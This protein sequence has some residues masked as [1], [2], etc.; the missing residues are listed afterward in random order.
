MVTE[1]ARRVLLGVLV[2]ALAC[3]LQIPLPA[4]AEPTCPTVG[5]GGSVTPSP[6][7][8]G[9]D[10]TDCD[11]TGALLV[12]VVLSDTN[13][14][15]ANLTNVDF[16][17]ATLTNANFTNATL[18]DATLTGATIT[19]ATFTPGSVLNTRVG[20]F[21][22]SYQYNAG[23]DTFEPG[24]RMVAYTGTSASVTIPGSA[25]NLDVTKIDGGAFADPSA[26]TSVTFANT[27]TTI[28]YGAF[29]ET[30]LTSLALPTSLEIIEA[31][32]FYGIATLGGSLS[33]PNS[34]TSI[35]DNAFKGTGFTSLTLG[36]SL[37]TIG[38]AA[39]ESV[40]ISGSL[41]IPSSTT[42]IGASAFYGTSF[43]GGLTLRSGLT[44]IGESAF[45]VLDSRG[46]I[47]GL[48]IPA[49]VTSIGPYAFRGN[50][51]TTLTIMSG[52][53]EMTIGTSA[54][55]GISTFA[56]N[57]TVP[58]RVVS[59]G[60]FAFDSAGFTGTLTL[61]NSLTAISEGAFNST[62]F[63]T[64]GLGN[65]VTSIGARAFDSV[66]TTGPLTLPEGLTTVGERA[67]YDTRITSLTLPST[68]T[69]IGP[70]AFSSIAELTASITLPS[71]LTSLG[72]AA[73]YGSGITGSVAIPSAVTA[74]PAS[75][76]G[77]TQV[78]A[79]TFPSGLTSIGAQAF[80]RTSI[81]TVTFPSTL[82]TIGA[83]AFAL[84]LAGSTDITGGTFTFEGP[85][86]TI[87]A[88]AFD[89]ADGLVVRYP[90]GAS[91]WPLPSALFGLNSR[92]IAVAGPP[93]PGPDPSSPI[94]E[95]SPSNSSQSSVAAV[96]QS[97][98]GNNPLQTTGTAGFQVNGQEIPVTTERGPRGSGLTLQAGS[99]A[100]TLRSQTAAGQRIPVSPDGSL[101]LPRTGQVPISGDGLEPN[102]SV[103]VTLFSDPI[104]LGSSVVSAEG[105]FTASPVI[106]STVSLG[107]HTLQLTGR[108][109]TGDPFV[110]SVGVLVETPAA[111]L[112]ANPVITVQP[113]II[114]PSASVSVTARG[115]QAGCRVTFILAG[116]R[117]NATA[118][119]KGVA[120]AQI[121]VPKKLPRT[122]SLRASVTG[123][124]CSAVAVSERVPVA[125]SSAR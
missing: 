55:A 45:E 36:S 100:F 53:S 54:F 74:V 56:G 64:V 14:T 28:G 111:A 76:F 68:L 75:V 33:I 57:L 89:G 113:K 26:I 79:V 44:T 120:Q 61:P 52:S 69:S 9:D 83:Q 8:W 22:Y 35:G 103:A 40:P 106:P 62:G 23:T 43:N 5:A 38:V 66:P 21:K 31:T 118:S 88:T 81:E 112:G 101:I 42:S 104:A 24:L 15:N 123:P 2:A 124:K 117:A 46:F 17:G 121:T 59:I 87:D 70:D 39:F 30:R 105:T 115:V 90:E 116:K 25:L 13:F 67:F 84:R 108:T 58:A 27:L 12:G 41:S 85:A 49:S 51:F 95:P 91:G 86:P 16:T 1:T 50:E 96:Q 65:S 4:L 102:S 32:A 34:V 107:A 97:D 114:K 6:E 92:Q 37:Q 11:L 29:A 99:V 78:S 82:T 72:S 19:G 20:D 63:I 125:R 3:A 122:V 7:Y 48:T 73:F 18:T 94:L 93:A 60:T 110:L 71:G 80:W 119:K 109:K 98:S 47:G 77:V 10:L